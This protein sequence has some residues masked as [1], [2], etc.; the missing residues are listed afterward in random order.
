LATPPTS[1]SGLVYVKSPDL[2]IE[3]LCPHLE[4]QAKAAFFLKHFHKISV[5]NCGRIDG[6]GRLLRAVSHVS[7]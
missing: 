4:S 3:F 6:A 1:K 2:A 5:Y 7:C